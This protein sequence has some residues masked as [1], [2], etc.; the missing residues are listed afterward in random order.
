MALADASRS[1]EPG[2]KRTPPVV[3]PTLG[4]LPGTGNPAM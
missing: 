3:Y 2:N 1:D 4:T